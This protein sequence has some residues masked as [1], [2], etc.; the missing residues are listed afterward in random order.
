[1]AKPIPTLL[2]VSLLLALLIGAT[3]QARAEV[4]STY[5]VDSAADASDANPGDDFCATDGGLCTLR[6]AIVEANNHPGADTIVFA[7]NP[8]L[9]PTIDRLITLITGLP[10]LT[11][12]ITIQGPNS[13][14]AAIVIDG[15]QVDANGLYVAADNVTIH[16]LVIR[17]F[18]QSGILVRLASTAVITGN[19]IGSFG[20]GGEN[21]GN[22]EN[23]IEVSDSTNCVIGGDTG[24]DR[25][26][27]S[28]NSKTGIWISQGG[29]NLV[30][31][32][33][34]GTD[35]TGALAQPNAVGG[36]VIYANG[37]T[38]GGSIPGR[39]N[40][41]SGNISYGV[42]ISGN[43]N[44]VI[45][46]YIGTDVTGSLAIPND[47]GVAIQ[48]TSTRSVN[49][50]IGS[51]L[52]GDANLIS[53]NAGVGVGIQEADENQVLG[54]VIGLN[55]A[56][57]AALPNSKGVFIKDG[58]DNEI[59]GTAHGAGNILAGNA[60]FGIHLS[61][62][63]TTGTLIK[64]NRVG[65]NA[66][67]KAIPNQQEGILLEGALDTVVGGTEAG[68]RNI[69]AGNGQS[70]VRVQLPQALGN[71]ITGNAIYDNNELGIELSVFDDTGVT[72][73]DRDDLD[74]GGN[75]LQNFPVLDAV[76]YVTPTKLN[77][78]GTLH[79]AASTSFSIH[80]YGSDHCDPSGHGEGQAY[81]GTFTTTTNASHNATFNQNLTIPQPYLYV[82]ATATDPAGN[83]SE[84]SRCLVAVR[85]LIPV[86]Y[87]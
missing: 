3:F 54:N 73:N 12:S 2:R 19:K 21:K 85:V 81:L 22:G 84:F 16:G 4:G 77:V 11:E 63:E 13:N 61:L 74:Q 60:I 37:N 79:S 14:G 82:T 40:L 45:G 58:V 53:G 80:V 66:A 75:N 24:A 32:N 1:M 17:N 31:G 72:A 44:V 38:I 35:A 9:T 47:Y 56:Q 6:A 26:L 70:G 49:N 25:N 28:G 67:G 76:T 86:V 23:G 65:V 43:D 15:N 7:I 62:P 33:Y 18:K 83:T 59:G 5:T 36:V 29:M 57:T 87:R 51:S 20:F 55:A 78:A 64:G 68:A 10:P 48:S 30:R 52:I 71:A 39:R 69:I 42:F 27:I 46:N 41:I 34:I 8:A 50:R